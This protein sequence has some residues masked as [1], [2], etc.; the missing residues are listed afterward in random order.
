MSAIDTAWTKVRLKRIVALRAGEGIPADQ[1]T[2]E[3]DYPV[4]GGNGIRGYTSAFTH[5]GEHVLIG[6]QG[7]LCGNVNRASGR[8]WASEHAVVGTP[9]VDVDVRWLA[10]LLESM[11]LNRYS[12][13]AAQPGLS[14]D[15]IANLSVCVPSSAEQRAIGDYLDR[16]TLRID[17]LIV[18]KQRML[19]LEGER[20]TGARDALFAG[21][22]GPIVKLGR[23][24]RTI[25]QGS[26]PQAE[27][28]H[29]ESGEWGVL[30][31]SSV[32]SGV[33]IP[34]EHKALP[35]DAEHIPSL[36]PRRGDLLVTRANTPDL[37]GD[38]CAVRDAPDRLMLCDL[39]YVLRLSPSLDARFAAEALLTS[40][41]RFQISSVARGTSQ[42]MV[43]LRGE[44]VKGVE[45]VIP[46]IETQLDV[47]AQLD[48]ARARSAEL[49]ELLRS[50]VALLRAR[51][52]AL[53]A[54][55]VTGQIS[56]P[57]LA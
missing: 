35:P 41:A 31:L 49:K 50:S 9:A 14:V 47:V 52:Q 7:A 56:V 18:A 48:G 8:F 38:T 45:I 22:S 33:F 6:R 32:K 3:G 4:Y 10:G 54:A 26:S 29:V 42:S 16:E 20:S 1:I 55:A 30:K 28:R 23:F 51:R 19:R 34:S 25:G 27:D 57:V 13:S 15:L 37:V 21:L 11:N 24:V 53:V 12:Q 36:V 44:D 39:I 46:P 40:H 2:L 43:K 5:T 17:A